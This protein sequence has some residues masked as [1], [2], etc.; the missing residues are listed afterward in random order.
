LAQFDVSADIFGIDFVEPFTKSPEVVT[1]LV[2]TINHFFEELCGPRMLNLKVKNPEK[3][4][5]NP[6]ELLRKIVTLTLSLV[7]EAEFVTALG[8]DLEYNPQI[9][10]KA[11]Q[12]IARERLVGEEGLNLFGELIAKVNSIVQPTGMQTREPLHDQMEVDEVVDREKEMELEKIYVETLKSMI[13]DS[14]QMSKEE[15]DKVTYNHHY[16]NNIIS[17]Q[18]SSKDKM[19]RLAKE[20]GSF[21]S[22]LPISRGS[23][24]FVRTDE[25]RMDVMKA[26]ITGPKGTPYGS[27]CFVFDIFFPATYPQDPPLVNLATTGN[28][29][30]RL[31]YLRTYVK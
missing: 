5:F 17:S 21:D 9:M 23:S 13:F 30:Y 18:S 6:R 3:Y 8:K 27:G 24:I 25:E 12:I 16:S 19:Q 26:V 10:Q 7:K 15:G 4:N 29:K 31:N 20:C 2:S 11:F 22:L 28:G 1:K 14:F